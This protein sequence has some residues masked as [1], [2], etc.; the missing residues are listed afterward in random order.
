M[1]YILWWSFIHLR[2]PNISV[3]FRT[4]SARSIYK[5]NHD[6]QQGQWKQEKKLQ[7]ELNRIM[8]TIQKIVLYFNEINKI[9]PT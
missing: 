7:S 1:I 4:C 2:Q 8:N 6:L 9:L 3:S 5:A